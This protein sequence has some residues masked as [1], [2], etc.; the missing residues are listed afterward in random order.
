MTGD[1]GASPL[2][3]WDTANHDLPAEGRWP[4]RRWPGAPSFHVLCGRVGT[5]NLNPQSFSDLWRGSRSPSI[6]PGASP[7]GTWETTN[8]PRA[9]SEQ[10]APP[11]V[12]QRITQPWP[13]M[14]V[15]RR[16]WPHRPRTTAHRRPTPSPPIY[17]FKTLQIIKRQAM[18][19][20]SNPTR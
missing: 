7:L 20:N 2:G 6:K 10:L 4:H 16:K 13:T 1:P 15:V 14:E 11:Q 8:L 12:V 17:I 19:P 3:T 18:N 9:K 5:T